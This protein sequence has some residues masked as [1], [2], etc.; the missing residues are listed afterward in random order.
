[1]IRTVLLLLRDLFHFVGVDLRLS[2][3]SRSRE[4]LPSRRPPSRV[5][6]R[7]DRRVIHCGDLFGP[8]ICGVQDFLQGGSRASACR[9]LA[10]VPSRSSAKGERRRVNQTF[11]SWEPDCHLAEAT[12]LD[13]LG[14]RFESVLG[15]PAQCRTR[16][17]SGVGPT[18]VRVTSGPA[19]DLQPNTPFSTWPDR[20]DPRACLDGTRSACGYRPS[21]QL[22]HRR[23]RPRAHS[24]SPARSCTG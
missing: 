4:P 17:S 2:P 24:R 5:P 8:N 19:H 23:P 11:A 12:Q 3:P 14:R 15:R 21:C 20:S 22:L 10:G 6:A 13:P 1:M 18:D 7:A 16:R 9:W